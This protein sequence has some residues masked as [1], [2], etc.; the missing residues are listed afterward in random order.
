MLG[1]ILGAAIPAVASLFGAKQQ[2][3]QQ[4]ALAREQMAFQERMS[5]T[6]YQRA[7]HDMRLAGI[8]PML[9]YMQGGASSPGGAMP[10]VQDVISPA[11]NSAMSGLRL[12]AELKSAKLQQELLRAQAFKTEQ[13][14]YKARS[15]AAAMQMTP[16]GPGSDNVPYYVRAK[17]N[18][19]L[20]EGYSNR[21]IMQR[22]KRLEAELPGARVRGSSLAAYWQLFGLPVVTGAAGTAIA[23][24][25]LQARKGKK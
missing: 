19:W 5:G 6:A 25:L 15:E 13:E 21:E 22:V 11:V 24:N 9:A 12:R 8:N 23:K 20:R 1:A 2:N 16:Q 18:E 17:V 7:V 3:K 14:G 10:Q 4:V